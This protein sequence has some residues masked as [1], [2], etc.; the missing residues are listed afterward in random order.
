MHWYSA[1]DRMRFAAWF[2]AILLFGYRR[3]VL[4]HTEDCG[5]LVQCLSWEVKSLISSFSFPTL[6][7]HIQSHYIHQFDKTFKN[8]FTITRLFASCKWLIRSKWWW[9]FSQLYCQIT[10]WTTRALFTTGNRITGIFKSSHIWDSI[11]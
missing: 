3:Q 6:T 11:P 4:L 8:I 10:L 1:S 7:S 5:S 9:Y 2:S